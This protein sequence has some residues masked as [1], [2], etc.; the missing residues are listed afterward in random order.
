MTVCMKASRFVLHSKCAINLKI[1]SVKDNS[2]RFCYFCSWFA[3]FTCLVELV[4]SFPILNSR[5]D[6]AKTN[7]ASSLGSP[8][9]II[10]ARAV[11]SVR[12]A[13]YVS[14]LTGYRR[15]VSSAEAKMFKVCFGVGGLLTHDPFMVR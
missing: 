9:S 8:I 4:V 2:A 13:E 15:K 1:S 11:D 12:Y 6:L 3:S 14:A 7:C 10:V 5:S